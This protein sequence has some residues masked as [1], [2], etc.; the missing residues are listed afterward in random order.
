MVVFFQ[1]SCVEIL[2]FSVIV[3]ESGAFG[4]KLGSESGAVMSGT[5]ALIKRS[6]TEMLSW[7]CE[8]TMGR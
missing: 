1:S 7:P 4:R 2:T 6:M 5:S 3:S 8:D